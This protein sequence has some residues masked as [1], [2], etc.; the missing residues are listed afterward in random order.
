MEKRTQHKFWVIAFVVAL[1]AV[2]GYR[3]IGSDDAVDGQASIE[4][5]VVESGDIIQTVATSGAVRPLIT[6]EVGSQLSGQVEE[7]FAQL[8]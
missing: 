4:T 5:A 1:L 8:L 7:I 6:V 2:V 3:W